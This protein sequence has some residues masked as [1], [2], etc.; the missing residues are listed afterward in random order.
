MFVELFVEEKNE[1]SELN[2]KIL[3]EN[4]DAIFYQRLD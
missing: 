1:I 2:L 4:E 3:V